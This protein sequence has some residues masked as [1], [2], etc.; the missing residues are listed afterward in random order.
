MSQAG[1]LP[2]Y[3]LERAAWLSMLRRYFA[4]ILPANITWEFTQLP[5]YTIWD[6]GSWRD[7]VFAALHCTAGDLLIAASA[8]LV[9]LIVFAGPRWPLKGYA[10]VAAVA[11]IFAVA[12]TIF[13]EWLNTEI[14]GSW[15]YTI[16]MPKLP[17]IGTGIAPLMQWI[18]IPTLAFWWARPNS[19]Q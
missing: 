2:S 11:V 13:S 5:L 16:A 17:L 12:Y 19:S 7:I 9:A 6:Q 8:L 18:L 4:F 3:L 15:A 10:R 14:R 1:V